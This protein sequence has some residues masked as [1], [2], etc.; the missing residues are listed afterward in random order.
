MVRSDRGTAV[1]SFGRPARLCRPPDRVRLK[2]ELLSGRAAR[3]TSTRSLTSRVAL[4]ARSPPQG[5]PRISIARAVAG[6]A[7]AVHGDAAEVGAA[8]ARSARQHEPARL[9]VF[10][11]GIFRGGEEG[12]SA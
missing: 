10:R 11:S 2:Q 8:D 3:E 5:A 9:A 6:M 4:L 1:G 12:L 7:N